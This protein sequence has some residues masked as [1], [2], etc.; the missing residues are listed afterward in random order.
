MLLLQVEVV[1]VPVHPAPPPVV[2]EVLE[3]IKQD[4]QLVLQVQ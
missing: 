1:A 2:E 3:G 4:Q